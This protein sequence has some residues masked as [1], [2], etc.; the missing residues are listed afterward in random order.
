MFFTFGATQFRNCFRKVF[1]HSHHTIFH[2]IGS[3][4]PS[5][6][7]PS[8]V[9]TRERKAK[10]EIKKKKR[11]SWELCL[12][13]SK[14]DYHSITPSWQWRASYLYQFHSLKINIASTRSRIY[15]PHTHTPLCPSRSPVEL[16]LSLNLTSNK[17]FLANPNFL[18][19]LA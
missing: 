13:M 15:T 18:E 17:T 6:L 7:P 1:K 5:V 16:I 19:F 12:F 2:N 4:H 14:R 3:F 10:E 11:S 8:I 9:C